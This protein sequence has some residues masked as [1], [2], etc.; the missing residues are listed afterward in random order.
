MGNCFS[1]RQAR[2]WLEEYIKEQG[3]E[4]ILDKCWWHR[5]KRKHFEEM[6]VM[7]INSLE[8]SRAQVTKDDISS[9]FQ[10]LHEKLQRCHYPQQV[11]N[12]DE[13]GFVQRPNKN[14]TRNCICIKRCPVTPSFIDENDSCHISIVAAV[15]LNGQS[16]TPLLISTT[17]KPPSEVINSPLGNQFHWF[18]TKKGYLTEEAM[19]YWINNI[20]LP[21]IKYAKQLIRDEDA[22]PLLIMDGLKA[23]QTVKVNQLLQENGIEVLILPPHSSH[24]VQCLD[25]CFFGIMK[26]HYKL[27]RSQLF[28]NDNKKA[29]KIERILK[30]FY[31]A[32]FQTII[33]TGWKASGIDF[34]YEK[35]SITKIALNKNRVIEKLI[36]Q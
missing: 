4:V 26:K 11:V 22:V 18:K 5:F 33:M 9:H 29:Q 36:N 7:K 23:H 13:S 15:T 14:T 12:M 17:E 1:P 32:S 19:L 16:L 25:L 10:K 31:T 35:G 34:I 3:R 20:Y 8:A 27:C 24:L 30:S 2:E 6:T 28:Q 21:Y